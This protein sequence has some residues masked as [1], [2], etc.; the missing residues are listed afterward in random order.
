MTIG[1]GCT[2]P[3]SHAVRAF[4]WLTLILGIDLLAACLITREA[5]KEL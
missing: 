1:Y 2:T 5:S 4:A 3:L